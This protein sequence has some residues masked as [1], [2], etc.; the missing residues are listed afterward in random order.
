MEATHNSTFDN[1]CLSSQ[2]SKINENVG[3]KFVL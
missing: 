3:L 1:R 2:D